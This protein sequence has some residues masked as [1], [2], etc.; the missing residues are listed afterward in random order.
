MKSSE[1]IRSVI[2]SDIRQDLMTDGGVLSETLLCMSDVTSGQTR[3]SVCCLDLS[4]GIVCSGGCR[5]HR[6]LAPPDIIFNVMYMVEYGKN[7]RF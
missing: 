3:L 2:R 4:D 6:A 5:R 7:E 1:R